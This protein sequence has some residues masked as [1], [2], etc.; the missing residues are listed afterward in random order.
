[1]KDLSLHLLD[2]LENSAKAGAERVSVGFDWADTQLCLTI[3][4][5][6]P[7]LPEGIRENPTDPFRTTRTDRPVGLG[8][9]LLRQ[10]AEQS[11]GNIRIETE[12]QRGVHIS[13]TFN[14]AHIDAKPL[15]DLATALLTAVVAWPNLD[16]ALAMGPRKQ[17][18]FD[19]RIVRDELGD[20]P[21]AHADVKS[22]LRRTLEDEFEPLHAWN[23]QLEPNTW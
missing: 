20:V 5:D 23:R 9:S 21:L 13:A 15:G 10:A 2:I 1:V 11:D 8:L 7:G 4:D 14:M 22:W 3:D 12:D 16:V 6:G 18:V 17:V 19:S